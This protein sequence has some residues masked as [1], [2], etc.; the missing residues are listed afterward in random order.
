MRTWVAARDSRVRLSHVKANGQKV[1]AA[2]AI[3]RRR[4]SSDV[5]WGSGWSSAR[6]GLQCRCVLTTRAQARA[7]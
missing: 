5:P 4:C 1:W 2:G 6:D 7:A 3:R